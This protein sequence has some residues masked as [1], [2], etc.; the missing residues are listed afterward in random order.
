[1][2]RIAAFCLAGLL[3]LAGCPSQQEIPS[4]VTILAAGTYTG[5]VDCTSKATGKTDVQSQ[6]SMTVEV[7]ATG[8]LYVSGLPYYVGVSQDMSDTANGI[9]GGLTVSAITEDS[10][11]KTV[12]ISAAGTLSNGTVTYTTT[13][14]IALVQSSATQLQISDDYAGT[15]TAAGVSFDLACTGT[16]IVQ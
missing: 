14:D 4:A 9:S 16:L 13:H 10:Q 2:R 7:S 6:T 3:F 15:S 11:T 12:A 1:M 5:N 8:Q